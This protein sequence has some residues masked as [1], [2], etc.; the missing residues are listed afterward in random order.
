MEKPLAI[1]VS[2]FDEFSGLKEQNRSNT[3]TDHIILANTVMI[4][5]ILVAAQYLAT[6]VTGSAPL[7]SVSSISSPYSG[8]QN[9]MDIVFT[10]PNAQS[11]GGFGFSVAAS[12][13]ILVVGAPLEPSNGHA[14]T[15][16]LAPQNR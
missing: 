4:V 10:N 3:M 8:S 12:G 11:G 13:N 16:R 9:V 1:F 15:S 14:Y 7:F 5:F 2:Y 6:P